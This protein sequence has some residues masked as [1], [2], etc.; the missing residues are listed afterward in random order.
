MDEIKKTME[1]V[2]E[3]IK[4]Q[5]IW[6]REEIEGLRKDMKEQIERWKEERMENMLSRKILR[7]WRRG[8][9]KWKWGKKGNNRKR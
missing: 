4:E 3:R 5:G 8:S 9:R 7:I 1:G 6:L 2:T